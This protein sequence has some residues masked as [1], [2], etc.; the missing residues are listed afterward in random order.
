MGRVLDGLSWLVTVRPLA[1][2]AVLAA[3]TIALGA[4][5]PQRAPQADNEIF[6]SDDSDVAVALSKLE[7]LFGDSAE[8]VSVTLV[9]RGEALTPEGLAQIERVI[10]GITSDPRVKDVLAAGDA[11]TSP[12]EPLAAVLGVDGF[13][14][15]TQGEVDETLDRLRREREL[16]GQRRVLDSLTGTD[17]DG[18]P[19]AIAIVRLRD[20][21]D[22]EALTEAGVLMGMP[23]D[24]AQTL[25]IETAVGAAQLAKESGTNPAILREMVTSPGGT[26]AA[27]LHEF[28]RGRFRATV[29]DA[30]MAAFRRARE[31]GDKT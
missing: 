16:A 18:M 25:A 19:I 17:A 31:L 15:T 12:A 27:A 11:V 8:T 20:P 10:D 5:I 14:D 6:L 26:T 28:E 2:L 23:R 29:M 7:A 24:M 1:T 30:A 3:I 9:F 22:V 4:G 21:G 13:A